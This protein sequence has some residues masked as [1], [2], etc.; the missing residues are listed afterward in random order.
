[1]INREISIK[2]NH[3]EFHTL[4]NELGRLGPVG[5]YGDVTQQMAV[6]ILYN[7][8]KR[9]YGRGVVFKDT[10]VKLNLGEMAALKYFI[11]NNLHNYDR[12]SYEGNLLRRILFEIDQ[13]L[14]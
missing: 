6:W 1:M 14:A 12:Q 7:F 13:K 5:P 2:L 4:R 8:I 3:A 10:K 9:L 11:V